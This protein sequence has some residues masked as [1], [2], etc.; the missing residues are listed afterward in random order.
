V[1]LNSTLFNVARV[2][3]PA[4]GGLVLAGLGPAWCFGLNGVS[5]MAA[6]AALWRMR[7]PPRQSVQCSEPFLAQIMSSLRYIRQ[8]IPLRTMIGLA[9]V[10]AL[11]G[12][13]YSTLMPAI[14]ADVLQVGEAGL[15]ALNAAIG[16]GAL[17]G[18]LIV[19]SLGAFRRKGALLTVGSFLFPV[20]LLLFAWSRSLAL[21]LCCLLV[22]GFA[23]VIQN[24]TINTLI[25]SLV[26]DALRGR[27]AAVF[28]LAFFGTSP[29]TALL[30]GALA[31]ALGPAQ[32]VAIGAGIALAAALGVVLAAPALCRLES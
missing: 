4:I 10:S 20:A 1:A 30:A 22:V 12:F 11:F 25:Q 27:V 7:F 16:L 24:S 29:F 32:A 9:A 3:G 19:A 21:S 5:F 28:I 8:N 2:A 15:G 31:E 6:I 13:F 26:P 23:F 17:V 14:A 18:S